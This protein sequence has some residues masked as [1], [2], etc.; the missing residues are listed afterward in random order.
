MKPLGEPVGGAGSSEEEAM[1]SAKKLKTV[2]REAGYVLVASPGGIF[3]LHRAGSY[4]A[5]GWVGREISVMLRSL[6]PNHQLAATPTCA[7]YVGRPRRTTMIASRAKPGRPTRES[8]GMKLRGRGGD[9][10]SGPMGQT[11]RR[12]P[13]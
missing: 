12:P 6:I 4:I 9:R 1:P 2:D 13:R 8:P 10:V 7:S 5:A 3:R 11:C